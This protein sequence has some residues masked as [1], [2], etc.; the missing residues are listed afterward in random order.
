M[1]KE[2]TLFLLLNSMEIKND[3]LKPLMETS[4]IKQQELRCIR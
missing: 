4:M 1:W 2:Q 3:F